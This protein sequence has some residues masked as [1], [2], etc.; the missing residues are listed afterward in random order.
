MAHSGAVDAAFLVVA[1]KHPDA[2][3]ERQRR[4]VGSVKP[5]HL[6]LGFR[7]RSHLF[8][9]SRTGDV[10]CGAWQAAP[11]S[12]G[13]SAWHVDDDQVVVVTGSVRWRN[14]PWPP[15]GHWAAHLAAAARHVPLFDVAEHLRGVFAIVR[16]AGG[17][18]VSVLPDPL[19]LRCV[20]Y[21]E[22]DDV[23]VVGSR[24]ALVAEV[25]AGADGSPSRD[26]RSTCWLAF[27]THRIGAATGFEGVRVLPPGATATIDAGGVLAV[28]VSTPWMPDDLF[29]DR[30]RDELIEL[31][32]DEIADGLR[33][34]LGLP[35]E[36]HV[37]RLTGGKDSRLMLAVALWAG[38]AKDFRYETVGPSS[39]PDVQVATELAASL[40]LD[41]E[42]KFLGLAPSRPYPDRVRDFVEATAGMLNIWDLSEPNTPPD[43]VC[44]VGLCGEA[45][46]T[47]RHGKSPVTCVDDLVAYVRDRRLAG[48]R[49]V[50][51]DVGD[52]LAG[53][54]MD[55]LLGNASDRSDPLDLLDSFEFR[56]RLRFTRMGPQEERVGHR[57]IV[58]LYSIDA[59]R[60]A[61]ALGGRA[62]ER[63]E[64]HFEVVRRCSAELASHR[65]V[66]PGW[67]AGMVDNVASRP[68][69]T[70]SGNR[71]GGTP[72][73]APASLMQNLHRSAFDDRKEFLMT[74]LTTDSR[75][76]DAV[77]RQAVI[78]GLARFESL[79][80]IERRQLYGAVTAALWLDSA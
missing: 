38:L 6:E 61:F 1:G 57:R 21:G 60:V 15:D 13:G 27:T 31:A 49:L 30:S 19:G 48:R 45:L 20:Y 35:V 29:Q 7:A 47:F 71:L 10:A 77:D 8:W 24:A 80:N 37:F 66:G 12:P 41:H 16:I 44:V 28:D 76:W 23:V 32:R 34:V 11:P 78:R 18:A 43:E 69:K 42:V 9:R 64:L 39:L 25:L 75:V 33:G 52:D 65:F 72:G 22:N 67:D 2:V 46:R 3:G 62:R 73:T 5:T 54:A 70:E 50:H 58:P 79:S 68:R 63:E 56:N 55:E 74:A 14:R 4:V 17:G 26:V 51:P 53:A 59:L 36:R 40:G